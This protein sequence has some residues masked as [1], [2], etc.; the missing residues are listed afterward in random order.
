TLAFMCRKLYA[1]GADEC[2][3]ENVDVVANQDLLLGGFLFGMI[4]KE[5]LEEAIGTSLRTSLLQYFRTNPTEN[6]TTSKFKQD[7]PKKI[8]TK[9]DTKIGQ[10]LE[11]FLSTG[12]LSSVSGLDQQQAS[13]F[14]IVAE[15]LNFL[16]YIAHFRSVHRGAFFTEMR[17]T[18]V[19]KLT[20]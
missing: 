2:A 7:F 20:P 12:N 8:F 5:R 6:F 19:R 15:K 18:T 11:Y 17:T 10:A 13:G 9:V 14:T 3:P 1:L 16:R 4:I